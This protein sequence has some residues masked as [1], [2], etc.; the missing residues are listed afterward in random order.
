MNSILSDGKKYP[1]FS[2]PYIL[3][4][5]KGTEF[6]P[7]D[8]LKITYLEL[9]I[10]LSYVVNIEFKLLACLHNTPDVEK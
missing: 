7:T 5:Q 4:T 6:I 1:I 3:E 8:N 9:K 10:Y 2:V